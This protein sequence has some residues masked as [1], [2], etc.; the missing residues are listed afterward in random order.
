MLCSVASLLVLKLSNKLHSPPLSLSLPISLPQSPL[1]LCLVFA[2]SRKAKQPFALSPPLLRHCS[3][4]VLVLGCFLPGAAKYTYSPACWNTH[5]WHHWALLNSSRETVVFA[6]SAGAA[7]INS[8]RPSVGTL[9]SVGNLS[10]A[11]QIPAC[12]VVRLSIDT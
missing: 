4:A 6:L 2:C 12:S 8:F 10:W 9:S 3:N 5:T 11:Y 1:G 7:C